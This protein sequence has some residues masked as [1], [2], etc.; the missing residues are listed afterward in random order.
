MSCA[1]GR[2]AAGALARRFM[3]ASVLAMAAF[4]AQAERAVHLSFD[5]LEGWHE[6]D[7]AEALE[8]FAASCGQL[9]VDWRALCALAGQAHDARAFF[10]MFFRPVQIGASGSA[11]ITAYYEPE[12]RAS[13]VRNPFYQHPVYALPPELDPATPW[14]TRAEIETKGAL[15]GR[16]LEIAWLRDPVDAYFLQV[17]GSGR[18]RMTDGRLVR[19]GFAGQNGHPRRL[20]STEMVARGLYEPHE[21]SVSNI[22]GW[23]RR[24]PEE[25]RELLNSDPSFVFF[26]EIDGLN[27]ERGPEGAM[28]HPLTP[29]RSVAVD[30]THVPL[31]APVWVESVGSAGLQRLMV[32]QDTG[33]AIRGPQRADVFFGTGADAGHAAARVREG[34]RLVVLLPI[35]RAFAMAPTGG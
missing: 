28:L 18:L 35:E 20:V 7:H 23:V 4:P 10:E 8:V 19:L 26:R 12:L 11:L 32:A 29:M 13:P 16:G 17:Q 2:R 6:D 9:G 14:L 15:E 24:H 30:P 31:G 25:G 34:G 5:A 33:G 21:V 27:E 1:A 3:A 22:R